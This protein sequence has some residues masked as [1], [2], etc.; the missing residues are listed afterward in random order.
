MTAIFEGFK[1][2]LLHLEGDELTDIP[3]DAGGLTRYGISQVMHPGVDVANLT[4][5]GAY[6]WYERNYWNYY[7]LNRINSQGIANKLMSFLINQNPK[8][9]IICLQRA[10]NHCG[11]PINEDGLL[12][13]GTITALN[14][15]DPLW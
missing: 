8:K 4:L 14:S 15:L 12:G 10:I 6:T 13:P 5:E 3:G 11:G 2:L 1:P 9:A 7:N